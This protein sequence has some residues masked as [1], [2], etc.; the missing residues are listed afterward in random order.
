[1]TP[2]YGAATQLEKTDMLDYADLVAIN[3]ADKQGALDALRDV[4]KQVRRNRVQFDGDDADLPVYLTVASDFND[5][6][7]NRFYRALTGAHLRQ[8]RG[9][10]PG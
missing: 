3:K 10:V 7:T 4:R 9:V 1:M 2:E 5:P 6:A 8:D